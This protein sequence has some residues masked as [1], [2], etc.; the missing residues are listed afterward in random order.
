MT[1]NSTTDLPGFFGQTITSVRPR[2]DDVA[3]N[4]FV[5]SPAA[6]RRIS[7]IINFFARWDLVLPGEPW[8]PF[9]EKDKRPN[10]SDEDDVDEDDIFRNASTGPNPK[11]VIK[12]RRGLVAIL[13]ANEPEELA[14]RIILDDSQIPLILDWEKALNLLIKYPLDF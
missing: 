4:G 5:V 1:T 13:K 7:G 6:A 2:G 8:M 14:N 3:V 9:P 11:Q 10:R 12:I